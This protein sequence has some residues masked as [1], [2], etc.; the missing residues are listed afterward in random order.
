MA[1]KKSTSP[2]VPT[3]PTPSPATPGLH[4]LVRSPQF[5]WWLAHGL[6]CAF[7]VFHPLSKHSL[8]NIV[9]ALSAHYCRPLR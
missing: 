6:T 7:D 1:D 4:A 5:V 9:E 2:S 8:R 3:P